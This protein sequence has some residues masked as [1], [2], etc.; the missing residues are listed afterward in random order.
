MIEALAA[1][2]LGQGEA[3]TKWLA[4]R[5]DRLSPFVAARV[6]NRFG[7]VEHL[8]APVQQA[9]RQVLR[10]L[11]AT[12]T[13]A[14]EIVHRSWWA[15]QAMKDAALGDAVRRQALDVVV[16]AGD[17]LTPVAAS[18]GAERL[19]IDAC[20]KRVEM[21][22]IL[23][24]DD[25]DDDQGGGAPP[26]EPAELPAV[27]GHRLEIAPAWLERLTSLPV[28]KLPQVLPWLERLRARPAGQSA[29]FAVLDVLARWAHKEEPG[30]GGGRALDQGAPRLRTRQ[31]LALRLLAGD[32]QRGLVT[33]EEAAT[34]YALP[35]AAAEISV[36]TSP[37][38]PEGEWFANAYKGKTGLNAL[39]RGL[40]HLAAG[41]AAKALA[42]LGPLL[43]GLSG[44]E[45]GE[46]G[47]Y[48]FLAAVAAGDQAMQ[49]RAAAEVA[50]HAGDSAI[51]ARVAAVQA[52]GAA[53]G[54]VP[55]DLAARWLR[56]SPRSEPAAHAFLNAIAARD[57]IDPSGPGAA[58]AR[59]LLARAGRALKGGAFDAPGIVAKLS[60]GL[61]ASRACWTVQQARL[62]ASPAASSATAPGAWKAP[63]SA[64]PARAISARAGAAPGPDG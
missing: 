40:A 21:A 51:A 37:G 25:D 38:E 39:Q 34:A 17:G 18:C 60:A 15:R 61:A 41:R 36:G 23:G 56:L 1:L 54:A 52:A 3:F 32:I 64:R 31:R 57:G 53:G 59:T 43:G 22:E 46:L 10:R 45:R 27:L 47:G 58:P 55:L 44:S 33:P 7:F 28:E 5:G 50:A 29:A 12:A 2:D 11:F 16:A 42:D 63:V 48:V 6:I 49:K 20:V 8:P 14:A 24:R 26:I 9:S 13:P 30:P 19:S 4:T 62:A 35:A